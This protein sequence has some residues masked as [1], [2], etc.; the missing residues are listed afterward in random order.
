MPEIVSPRWRKVLRDMRLH[1]ARTLL[2]VLAIATALT[3][4]GALLD[5]WALVQRVTAQTYRASH[6][7]S[8]TLHLDR[9]DD[10]LLAQ[11][12]TL[13]GIAAA[14]ARRTVVATVESNGVR[15][16]AEI[17]ALA[18]FT[19]PDIGALR[20]E[21]G[22]W[23]PRDGEIAIEHSS[24]EFARVVQGDSLT[25]QVGADPHP[26]RVG[27]VVRDVGLPPGWM[28]HVVYLYATPATL[29]ALGV[30][31]SF[32]EL[33]IVV[34]D[35]GA[36]REAVRR[37]ARSVRDAIEHG[38]VHVGRIDVPEPG[39]HPHAAQMDSLMLMQ[40]AFAL[41]T[42]L[43]CGC[44]VVN[45]FAALLAGQTRE[46]GIMKALG[47]DSGQLA[48]MYLVSAAT[49]GALAS[50][51]ALPAALAIGR[52]YAQLKADMLNFPIAGFAVPWWAIALQLA[53]GI[54]LPVAA[55]AFPVARA[56]RMPVHAALSAT[57]MRADDGGFHLRRRLR[58]RG[59]ARPLALALGNAFRRRARLLLTLLA[60]AAGGAVYVGADNLR[61]AVRA[62]VDQLFAAQRYDAT[63][64]TAG[65]FPQA[66]LEA[67]A[68]KVD[69]VERAQALAAASASIVHPDGIDGDAFTLVGIPVDGGI[70]A[71]ENLEGRWIEDA[72][73]NAL[74]VSRMLLRDES[75]ARP[76]AQVTLTSGGRQSL[77]TIV[78]VVE[79]SPQSLAYTSRAA[80]NALQGDERASTLAVATRAHGD[81]AVLAVV[82]RL[83]A[84]L[85]AAEIPVA[86]SQLV[87][88]AKRVYADHLQMVVEFLGAMG[89]V[90]IA[91][92]GMGLAS[93]M[94]LAVLERTRE[95]GIMRALGARHAMIVA[96]IEAE[97]IVIALLGFVVSLPL[98][99][100]ISAVLA[101]AF[102]RVMFS[103]PARYVPGA[104]GAAS[105][106]LLVVCIAALASLWPAWRAT[107]ISIAAALSDA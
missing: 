78:G 21:S 31:S 18:D 47:A 95:I 107:R 39:R 97:G 5:A 55:V 92:G 6:P 59:V 56:C 44:L 67:V 43:V 106:L 7:P 24:L 15:L 42:L 30:P 1:K 54:L 41:L 2:V 85:A 9:V 25:L 65:R 57:G 101:E 48:A 63:L 86:S 28:D 99:V 83:R 3:G 93:T 53:V 40:G 46:I 79:G 4:A 33:Q 35:A 98:S 38:G 103:V 64:R 16:A 13:P 34:S 69:G 58:L 11:V 87:S 100:P 77:W 23:P 52:P 94:S 96:M 32:D 102:G 73:R 90:M 29:A 74:V 26:L 27:G 19:T 62:S 72:D 60:L 80:L 61:G 66:L 75:G 76:G 17:F 14:R 70:L 36:D 10:A 22:E 91:V 37:T 20:A 84:A 105:W 45:L 89:W 12:R 50:L 88:E 71:P 82:L 68:A 8:A 49:L 81:A 51:V 104:Y